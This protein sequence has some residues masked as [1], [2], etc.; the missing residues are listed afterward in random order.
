[1]RISGN[2]PSSVI[3]RQKRNSD[4]GTELLISILK[5]RF[6]NII[7]QINNIYISKVE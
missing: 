6:Y 3:L 1:M 5:C 7:F 4:Q 2:E